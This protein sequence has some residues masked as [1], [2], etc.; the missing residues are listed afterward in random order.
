MI[1]LTFSLGVK[2]MVTFDL[3]IVYDHLGKTGMIQIKND[4]ATFLFKT[5][6]LRSRDIYDLVILNSVTS[7]DYLH[8][9]F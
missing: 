9:F 2:T 4:V 7:K 5:F 8:S 1:I 6:N 3:D